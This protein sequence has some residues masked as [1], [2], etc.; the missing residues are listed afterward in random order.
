MFCKPP[1][2]ARP[3][4]E[5]GGGERGFIKAFGVA[6]NTVAHREGPEVAHGGRPSQLDG[7][8]QRGYWTVPSTPPGNCL[9]S[10]IT[11][12]LLSFL[13]WTNKCCDVDQQTSS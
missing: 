12:L 1:E 4:C 13:N 2:A 6:R 10:L 8:A 3:L 11:W 9:G 5:G 7:R